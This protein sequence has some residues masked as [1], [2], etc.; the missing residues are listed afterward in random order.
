[1]QVGV[2]RRRR[3]WFFIA[4]FRTGIHA[5][6]VLS[7]GWARAT[8]KEW[9]RLS[10]HWSQSLKFEFISIE[11]EQVTTVKKLI[12]IQVLLSIRRDL[13]SHYTSSI[14]F[15]FH[16]CS[17]FQKL[18]NPL[19]GNNETFLMQLYIRAVNCTELINGGRRGDFSR[20]SSS[21]TRYGEAILFGVYFSAHQLALLLFE[22]L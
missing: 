14:L 12:R 22:D 7:A 10:F 2:A 13:R 16:F 18:M 20:Y 19:K 11:N 3:C 1:M 9:S 4:F 17:F 21:R 15:R 8:R 5:S 6:R